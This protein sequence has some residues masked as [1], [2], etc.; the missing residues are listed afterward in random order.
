[1]VKQKS[2]VEGHFV[3]EA[4]LTNITLLHPENS[5]E[6]VFEIILAGYRK[7]FCGYRK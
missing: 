7:G 5:L 6:D 3:K 2:L 1:M 4:L